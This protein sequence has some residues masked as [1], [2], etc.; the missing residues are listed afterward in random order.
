VLST[1][2]DPP[3]LDEPTPRHRGAA[4]LRHR[5]L[6]R[7]L[8]CMRPRAGRRP[9]C[10]G[11]SNADM[12]RIRLREGGLGTGRSRPIPLGRRRRR[13]LDPGGDQVGAS[14]RHEVGCSAESKRD[15]ALIDGRDQ[16]LRHR[17]GERNV[18]VG[19]DRWTDAGPHHRQRPPAGER[20][21]FGEGTTPY[22]VTQEQSSPLSKSS[23][24]NEVPK[25]AF[26]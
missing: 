19:L 2:P 12:G 17:G 22:Q 13:R 5:Q 3:S 23:I 14:E 11:E 9:R 20:A 6:P 7:R 15:S 1:T 24:V 4:R 10:A 18:D 21:A 26:A 25:S 16:P 8:S